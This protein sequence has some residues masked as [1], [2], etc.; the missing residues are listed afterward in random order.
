MNMSFLKKLGIG[1]K[2][3]LD[4]SSLPQ[5]DAKSFTNG[6]AID[7][8]AF[9]VENGLSLSD[10]FCKWLSALTGLMLLCLK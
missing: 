4:C 5:I 3:L 1:S 6:I 7:L 10:N 2:N 8:H 9:A